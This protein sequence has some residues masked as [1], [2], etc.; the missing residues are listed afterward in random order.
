MEHTDESPLQYCRET[1]P[2]TCGPLNHGARRSVA[3]SPSAVLQRNRFRSIHI[4]RR[5]ALKVRKSTLL[6]LL[7]LLLPVLKHKFFSFMATWRVC[8]ADEG[9]FAC[10]RT[11]R[12]SNDA[13]PG[14]I[15]IASLVHLHAWRDKYQQHHSSP[16]AATRV[17]KRLTRCR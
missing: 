10:F 13:A 14:R 1:L 8:A 12:F 9:S 16:G 6:S 17:L 11:F 4:L 2:L 15:C 3:P 7:L 5:L